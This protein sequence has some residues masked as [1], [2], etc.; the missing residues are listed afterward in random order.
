[1]NFDIDPADVAFREEVS[2]FLRDNL[3]PEIAVR[4][5]RN[6]HFLRA[7][8]REW[9]RILNKKGWSGQNWPKEWGGTGW[10]PVRQFIFE[11]ECF[12]AGAPPIDT[13]GF[14]MIG[15]V[16]MNFG[17]D[18]L[19]REFGPKILNGDVFWGQGFSEPDAGSDLGSLRTTAVRNGDDYVIN[20]QKIWTSYVET[21]EMIF[22]LV[23]TDPEARQRG[24]SMVL[25]D[26]NAPGIT[27]RPIIDIGECH[28][29]NEVFFDNV[30][31]PAR[32]L[33]GEEGK[34]WHYAKYLLDMERAFSAEWPRNKRYLA[35]L[36]AMASR[37]RANGGRLIDS[38][39]FAARLAQLEIDLQALEWLTLRAL[40][41]R[42]G[43][44]TLPVG[45]LLKVRGSELLQK[46]GEM[47]VEALGDYAAYFYADP[48]AMP[49]S[50][51]GWPPGP[52]HAPGIVADF[53][54][55]RAT[56]IYGGANEVQRTIIAK[57]FLEL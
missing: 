34:G 40:Y 23:K 15:P 27:I 52:D 20:G 42:K 14:K 31:T 29:L 6:Y 43:G 51:V 48:R 57:T 44:T 46:I 28:T 49:V 17:S 10:S 19:K 32:Y 25:V 37:E 24:I 55:R 56:T 33:V 12:M 8:Q 1:M 9:T 39:G 54:Y 18:E 11:D 50:D 22:V 35:Q 30:R 47:Q 36:R 2:A 53:M 41:E 3:P 5:L 38:P 13:A 4:T 16:I 26:K 7:D 21:A 45:S